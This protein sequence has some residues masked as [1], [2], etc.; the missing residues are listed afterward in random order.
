V[1]KI[2]NTK[3]LLDHHNEEIKDEVAVMKLEDLDKAIAS[4]L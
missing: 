3:E 2:L 1:E 4:F